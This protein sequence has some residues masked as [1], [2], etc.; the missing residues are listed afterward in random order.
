M[1][2]DIH[3]IAQ[4]KNHQGKWE[5]I[6]NIVYTG[7]CYDTFAILADVRNGIG[8]AGVKT[9]E[10]FAVISEPKGLPDDLEVDEEGSVTIADYPWNA[11][12]EGRHYTRWLGDHS[13]SYLTLA[14]IKAYWNEYKDHGTKHTDLVEWAHFADD[15]PEGHEDIYVRMEWKE[16][17]DSTSN[18][19]KIIRAMESIKENTWSAETDEDVRIVFGF[20]S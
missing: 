8:F 10:G 18:I 16:T 4:T 9:G 3:M 19:G 13:H 2:T 17:Y 15:K 6:P 11:K 5:T 14:E 1:G 12:E 20:D 7:R